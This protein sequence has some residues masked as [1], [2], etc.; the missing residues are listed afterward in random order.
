MAALGVRE[1]MPEKATDCYVQMTVRGP[2]LRQSASF[3]VFPIL[4]AHF[5]ST[6]YSLA[7]RIISQNKI[8]DKIYFRL[9]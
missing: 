4:K 6:G 3:S 9:I 7:I 5:F 2:I 8:W 1:K